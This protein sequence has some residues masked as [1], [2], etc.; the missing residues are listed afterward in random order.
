MKNTLGWYYYLPAFMRPRPKLSAAVAATEH[1]GE[2][3]PDGA[4]KQRNKMLL[5]EMASQGNWS[6]MQGLIDL[7]GLNVNEEDEKG[8][9]PLCA[10]ASNG[11]HTV[12]LKL[13]RDYRVNLLQRRTD[14]GATALIAAAE[15]REVR[16]VEAL[17]TCAKLLPVRLAFEH[18]HIA[19]TDDGLTAR[20]HAVKSGSSEIVAAIDAHEKHCLG[21]PAKCR[22]GC[23]IAITYGQQVLHENEECPMYTCVCAN[24]CGAR[25]RRSYMDIH[26]GYDCPK[27]IRIP[28]P[29]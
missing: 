9:L 12:V 22:H 16:S 7:V 17:L 3:V 24:G 8:E 13:F 10:A 2:G 14:D 23:G 21:R 11:H 27:R 28:S 25:V 15:A 19:D 18:L 26:Q 5:C 29:R 1:E 6:Q 20:Q 4:T